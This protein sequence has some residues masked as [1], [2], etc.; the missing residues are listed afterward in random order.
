MQHAN[1]YE[2]IHN[3]LT[4][5]RIVAFNM[6]LFLVT[7]VPLSVRLAQQD[8][9]NRSSAAEAPVPVVTPPPN[10]P[11][12]APVIERVTEWFGKKGDTVVLIGGNFG[13]YQWGS[14]VYVGNVE[15]PK[16]GVVR[17]S[18]SV[19]EVQIPSGARTGKVWVMVNGKQATWDGSLLLTDV[20]RAAKITIVKTGATTGVVRLTNAT[21][22]RRGM[23]EFA[24]VSEPL[25]V[26][27]TGGEVV[28]MSAGVDSLGKKTKVEFSFVEGLASNDLEI[29]QVGYPGI[30]T[31]EILRTEL[32]DTSGQLVPVFADPLGVKI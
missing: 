18:N 30:G 32:Y 5:K 31:V 2:R 20:A 27:V 4:W 8:T 7:V 13:D 29:M 17:W 21:G 15:A 16:E 14:K 23:V 12:G 6:V 24:H 28:G 1:V 10:Y 22:V 11:N 19:I 3:V 9:E 26:T 25:S